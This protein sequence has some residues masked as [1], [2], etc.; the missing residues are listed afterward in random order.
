LKFIDIHTHQHNSDKNIISVYN[1]FISDIAQINFLS[2]PLSLSVHPW[3]INHESQHNI[4]NSMY[5]FDDTKI[6]AVGECG[7]DKLK[8]PDIQLQIEIFKQ[9]IIIS[10]AAKKPI[11]IH[12][13]KALDEILK[14][15]KEFH[16]SQPW[17]F[18]RFA[19]K[20]SAAQQIIEQNC[21]VSFG[22]QFIENQS[23]HKLISHIPLL[24]I[25]FE[26]DDADIK[27]EVIY[28]KVAQ[29]LNIPIEKLKEQIF[30]N[31]LKV[32]PHAQ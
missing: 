10:E 29:L 26:T 31:F 32:F 16:C 23:L 12:C 7:L 1:L 3:Y 18:H 8:G 14:L 22:K 19:G 28:N 25:F 4:N 21:Y 30:T 2:P 11:I 27:I 17:I 5:N 24:N 15:R 13:V 9:L 6:F 20:L